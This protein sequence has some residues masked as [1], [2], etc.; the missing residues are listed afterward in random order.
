MGLIQISFLFKGTSARVIPNGASTYNPAGRHLSS[1]YH[2][3]TLI[4]L[5]CKGQEHVLSS[6]CYLCK[7]PSSAPIPRVFQSYPYQDED[8]T[9][10]IAR[11]E[12]LCNDMRIPL[13]SLQLSGIY[14]EIAWFLPIRFC[15]R[16]SRKSDRK[17]FSLIIDDQMQL[18]S[19]ELSH[20]T[21][22]SFCIFAEQ[23]MCTDTMIVARLNRSRVHKRYA[24]TLTKPS[25]DGV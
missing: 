20:G 1:S 21:L 24:G 11:P 12:V 7:M 25:L 13:L 2:G 6:L 15:R 3:I 18:E 22:S 10:H 8:I 4:N 16:H 5:L 23:M 19:I 14:D 9:L 17:N